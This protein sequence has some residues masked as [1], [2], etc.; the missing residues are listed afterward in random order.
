MQE[1]NE[2]MRFARGMIGA[3]IVHNG[4]ACTIIELL[5]HK[6]VL[7]IEADHP[8]KSIQSDAY[9]NARREMRALYSLPLLNE[10]A[11]ALHPDL[12]HLKEFKGI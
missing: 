12:M 8:R 6:L 5:E 9:G 4:E 11:D 7:I 10:T 3:R 1:T 2:I